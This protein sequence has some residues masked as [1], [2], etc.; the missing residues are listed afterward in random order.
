MTISK[1]WRAPAILVGGLFAAMAAFSIPAWSASPA[2]PAAVATKLTDP[3]ALAK[4]W[5]TP[6]SSARVIVEFAPPALAAPASFDSPAA[7]DA[8]QTGAVHAIQ[9]QII[10]A[11][12]GNGPLAGPAADTLVITRMDFSPMFAVNV[13]ADELASLAANPQV[14]RIHEDRIAEPYLDEAVPLVGMG[15]AYAAG[16]TGNG[17][18]VA[19]LDSGGR[20]SHEFLSSKIVSAACYSTT[21]PNQSF[22]YCPGGASSSINIDSANDCEPAPIFGC[23]HGTHVAGIS[24]GFNTNRQG[25]EPANGVS[26]NGSLISINVFSTFLQ[27]ACGQGAT[28]PC[29][30]TYNSDQIRGLERVFALRNTLNIASV[31]MSLGGGQF[32]NACDSEPQKPI[33]DQLRAANIATVIAAGN[34]GFNSSVGSPGCISSAITVAS[35][36]KQDVRS[37]FSNWGDLIDVVAPGSQI[38]SS[39]VSGGSNTFYDS[40]SGTSMASPMVAG[41]WAA[42]RSARPNATV[43][44]IEAALESTGLPISSAGFTKPRIRVDQALA[45]LGGGG[46]VGPVNN[47]FASRTA[48]SI[49]PATVT[50]NNIGATK[51]AGEPNHANF[52]GATTSVWWRFTPTASGPINITTAG[53]N[54]DTVLA[55]YTGSSV[56]G[57]TLVAANDDANPPSIRTSAVAFNGTAGVQY[58]IAVAGFDSATG[59]ITLNLSGTPGG[60]TASIVSAVTPVAR[61]TAVNGTVT[62]FATILNTGNATATSCSIAMPG[63]FPAVFSFSARNVTTGAPENPGVPVNIAAGQGR[64]FVISFR[65]TATMSASIPLVFDCANTAPAASV[66]GLNTFLLTGTASAPADLVS[67]AVTATNDGIMNVPLGGTGFASLAA[68]NIGANASLQARLSPNPIGVS[69]RTL[70]A[71]LSMCQTNPNTGACITGQ[72]SILNFTSNNGQTV[73]FSA[74]V[75]SNGQ[76]I[77]FDPATKRLFVHF[78]QGNNPVGSASVAVRTTANDPSVTTASAD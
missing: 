66:A 41:A 21:V 9:D 64:N 28:T 31:N 6:G 51:E 43:S 26:R 72:A 45:A 14:V 40:L 68:V 69:G 74:F 56:A 60:G 22:S 8:A 38:F 71:T 11:V 78:F 36:T 20:R 7:A 18:A 35:S 33:I 54:F 76:P 23:G 63:G 55:V 75:A 42:L 34:N 24:A 53:S 49:S 16:A 2:V 50:G 3:P 57:L 27:S 4:L 52:A 46:P 1:N 10:G 59:N 73:T 30:R 61:A 70:A 58:Q 12:F 29:I 37:S 44:Q 67:I 15:N 19:V 5:S 13:T 48:I 25:G 39:Y 65:P 47:N 32:F 77:A 17:F 62:A